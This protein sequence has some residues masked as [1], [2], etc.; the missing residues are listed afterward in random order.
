MMRKLSLAMMFL[1]AAAQAEPASLKPV[2]YRD[3]RLKFVT[4]IP[5][6]WVARQCDE[7]S[8]SLA[9]VRFTNRS[10][11]VAG[12]VVSVE[13]KR[14]DLAAAMGSHVLFEKV[15]G[16]WVKHGRFDAVPAIPIQTKGWKGYYAVANCGVSDSETGFHAAAGSCLTAII[17][18]GSRSA[19]IE[20]DGIANPGKVV[21]QVVMHFNF[22]R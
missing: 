12:W 2:I 8:D 19:V 4:E 13:I 5:S 20:S 18:N 11:Q 17:S 22:L 3:S 6:S 10:R 9:C 16:G 7:T 14:C 1:M 15:E 21:H